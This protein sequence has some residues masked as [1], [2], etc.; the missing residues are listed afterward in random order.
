VCP[1]PATPR[2]RRLTSQTAGVS[3]DP[4]REPQ[5]VT[6]RRNRLGHPL[7]LHRGAARNLVDEEYVS[8]FG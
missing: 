6:S 7:A 2:L 5:I 1:Y 8:C 4:R 3:R